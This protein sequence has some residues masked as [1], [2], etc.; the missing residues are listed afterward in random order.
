[1][2]ETTATTAQPI[3]AMEVGTYVTF[4]DTALEGIDKPE[5][6]RNMIGVIDSYNSDKSEVW[7]E[8]LNHSFDSYGRAKFFKPSTL[9][10]HPDQAAAKNVRSLM[11]W[12]ARYHHQQTIIRQKEADVEAL[13]DAITEAVEDAGYCS[14]YETIV[15]DVNRRMS[16]AGRSIALKHRT[17]EFEIEVRVQGTM[18][19]YTT[20]TVEAR[21]EDD[22]RD[23]LSDDPDSFFDP[24]EILTDQARN[25]CFDDVD[26]EIR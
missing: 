20:V 19:G 18:Y 25:D 23:M 6:W 14:E 9:T 4:T 12:E 10:V 17:Q 8:I 24:D 5:M 13:T 22:A 1:M 11:A 16:A 15:D 3:L 2:T 21:T 26:V 7:V